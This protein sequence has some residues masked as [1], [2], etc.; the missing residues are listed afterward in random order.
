MRGDIYVVRGPSAEVGGRKEREVGSVW[1]E[2]FDGVAIRG[3]LF[4]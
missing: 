2:G 4:K 3:A 1:I